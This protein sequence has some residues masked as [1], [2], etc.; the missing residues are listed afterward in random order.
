MDLCLNY[1]RE[2]A[3]THLTSQ[4]IRALERAHEETLANLEDASDLSDS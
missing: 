3:K 4:Q 1:V 2:I